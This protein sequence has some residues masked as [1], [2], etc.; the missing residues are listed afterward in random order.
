MYW[1]GIIKRNL[2]GRLLKLNIAES[3]KLLIE[4]Y[5]EIEAGWE[6]VRWVWEIVHPV[7]EFIFLTSSRNG[8]KERIDKV[9]KILDWGFNVHSAYRSWQR[10]EFLPRYLF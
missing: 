4:E 9:E 3:L 8:L 10:D 1:L 2:Y 5:E 7:S 6:E